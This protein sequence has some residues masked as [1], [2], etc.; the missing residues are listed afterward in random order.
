MTVKKVLLI[1]D[2][3]AI[4]G[5]VSTYFRVYGLN[6]LQ[7]DNGEMGIRL[8]SQQMDEI[9]MVVLDWLLPDMV[10]EEIIDSLRQINEDIPILIASGLDRDEIS[11]VFERNNNLEFVP[12][13]FNLAGLKQ[14]VHRYLA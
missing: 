9:G 1:D 13:P 5:V 14:H 10:G 6:V 11:P 3:P 7:A 4:R 8:F 12:K 2:E